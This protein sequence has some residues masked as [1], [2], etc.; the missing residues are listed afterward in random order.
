M[1]A[2]YTDN[3]NAAE[4]V[5]SAATAMVANVNDV[6]TGSVTISGTA[7]QGQTLTA[8]HTLSDIDGLGDI[9]YFWKS[10]PVTLGMGSSYT[11]RQ[12]DVGKAISVVA[13]YRDGNGTTERVTSTETA[14]VAGVMVGTEQADKLMG[15]AVTD[16]I[17]GLGAND[18]L[19]GGLGADQLDGGEGSDVYLIRSS[20]DYAQGERI[21]DTGSSGT[22]E[23][24]FAG[25]SGTLTLTGTV[26]GIERLVVG[27]GSGVNAIT[28]GASTSGIDASVLG[29]AL[30]IIGDNGRNSLTGG[31]SSD[32]LRGNG[33]ADT[34]NVIAG[35]DRVLDLGVGGADVL[36]VSSGARVDAD[37]LA[38]WTATAGTR[39]DGVANLATQG[40]TVNLAAI[41]SGNGFTVT[42][43]GSSAQLTGS[44]MADTLIGGFSA[45]TLS[46]GLGND[47]LVG[48]VGND[49]LTGGAGA[50]RFVLFGSD[51]VMDYSS[52]QSDT[53][54]LSGLD[55]TN[56]V[57]FTAVTGT[58]DASASL[59]AIKATAAASGARLSSGSGSDWLN[60][61]AGA[62]SLSS[63]AG[64]DTLLGEMGNDT[65]D[66][67]I[68]ADRMTG[69]AGRDRFVF[70]AG[71]SGQSAALRDVINDFAKGSSGDWIDYETALQIG[72]SASAASQN[73]ASI[74]QST[75]VVT[76]APGSGAIIGDALYDIAE[77]FNSA[78]DTKGEF[79][80]FKLGGRGDFHLFISDGQ[81]GVT[82]NDVVV[83]LVGLTSITGA[84]ITD[85]NLWLA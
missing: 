61:K 22:D 21:N 40:N 85:G 66:G 47:S 14:L 31:R 3:F 34:F 44:G 69:G 23:I 20:A 38:H 2:R 80:L 17:S 42:N 5:T 32:V 60:G 19:T 28:T 45:D 76:F 58:L 68:G 51:T 59:A 63:G 9:T 77:S 11:L 81:Q 67:G 73:Q 18:V 57:T 37:V 24:R 48:G 13:M 25:G 36:R 49:V 30:E 41:T 43:V 56:V 54:D 70:E 29:G 4:S 10:G 26:T 8:S 72:G 15:S 64:S 46:G 78:T 39:N 1:T 53:I 62:D 83:Q 33:G 27:T 79:A 16:D 6:S 55:S 82:P 65:I 71:D 12:A 75:G 52:V 74:N 7:R 35:A 50:D 84:N